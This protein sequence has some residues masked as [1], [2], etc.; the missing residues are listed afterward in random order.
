MV[1]TPSHPGTHVA[2]DVTTLVG[3]G[4]FGYVPTLIVVVAV[5][6]FT[7]VPVTVYTVPAHK[8]DILFPVTNGPDG[9][10]EY[11]IV[12]GLYKITM[13]LQ[14]GLQLAGVLD[15]IVGA[16]GPLTVPIVTDV[17]DV[18]PVT[19]EVPVIVYVV[20]AHKPVI[21]LPTIGGI[22]DGLIE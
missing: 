12:T 17:V 6:P 19:L 15:R 14:P 5:Q 18:H 3:A 13:P 1:T 11:T 22:T 21:I 10:T 2:F 9:E 7:S 16:T 8:A 20:P 4:G